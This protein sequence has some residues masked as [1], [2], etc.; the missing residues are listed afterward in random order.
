M[1]TWTKSKP[2]AVPHAVCTCRFVA[3]ETNAIIEEAHHILNRLGRDT[4]IKIPVSAAGLPAIKA[5]AAEDVKITAT[6]I[7]STMQGILA[8]LA[9]A[10][11]IAV[12]YNRMENNCT[13]PEQVIEELRAFIDG[14]DSDA[15][16]LAASFKN[17]AQVTRAYAAG[18]PKRP[19][20]VLTS[21]GLPSAWPV[22]TALSSASNGTS[23][24]SGAKVK[25]CTH[26]KEKG[27]VSLP[28]KK[29]RQTTAGL[30]ENLFQPAV[31]IL[32]SVS[33][34]CDILPALP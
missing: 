34:G 11:Y 3:E 9:G 8:V 26:G 5:L 19:R 13:E 18:R 27:T 4:F 21:S 29:V 12:Y 20:S 25:P 33:A 17:V 15:L 32:V 10:H 7:Y 16:I 1:R 23:S 28:H 30:R 14:S 22:L 6:A 24:Q 2:S 31:L